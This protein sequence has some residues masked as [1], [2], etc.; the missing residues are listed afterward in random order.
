MSIINSS[1]GG[2][3]LQ[4]V[5]PSFRNYIFTYA[6]PEN[7]P[8][9]I[10]APIAA[11]FSSLKSLFGVFRNT[12]NVAQTFFPLSSCHYN[13]QS[14][15]LRIGSKI[16]PAK[17]PASVAEFFI[18]ASKAIGSVS[19]I[20]HCPTMNMYS[21]NK[22][23]NV[24]NVETNVLMSTTSISNNFILGCDLEVYANAEK[25]SIFSGYNSTTDDIFI[26]LQFGALA[27]AIPALRM[28]FYA[29]YDSLIV[30]ENNTAYVKF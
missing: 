10:N 19:D 14:Y 24:A 27:A 25:E 21:Y 2:Q 20:N 16:S 15:N 28:D 18:E 13:L 3:P 7:T 8:I 17:A 26:Q 23:I 11:K 30:C 6:L 29:L 4:Y 22:Q 5:I 9:Q 1:L 12:A